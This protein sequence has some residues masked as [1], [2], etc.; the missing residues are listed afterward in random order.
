MGIIF[1]HENRRKAVSDVASM[2]MTAARTAPK[3]RGADNLVIAVADRDEIKLI[4]DKM[5]ELVEKQG[6]SDF[7]LRDAENILKADALFLIGTRIKSLG[8]AYCGLCGHA[9][10][11]E[12]ERAAPDH[13]CVYNTHDLGIAVGSAVS[14]AADCRVDN[15]I[16]YSVG[17][18][19]RELGLLGEGVRIIFGIPLSATAKNPFFDRAVPPKK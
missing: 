4:C 14:V 11:T 2:M 10:C 15:R 3:G 12:R 8:L 7:F 9:N 13:P 16:M 5:I 19:V 17:M 6:A 1:E 18:A